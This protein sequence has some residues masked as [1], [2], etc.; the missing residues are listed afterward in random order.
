MSSNENLDLQLS[1]GSV[2]M[3]KD[4]SQVKFL[5]L[6]NQALSPKTQE[7]H[8]P[9]VI[10]TDT[11]GNVF[12]RELDAFLK[13]YQFYNVDGELEKRLTRLIV[14]NPEDYSTIQDDEDQEDPENTV[15][16]I[17]DDESEDSIIP[18]SIAPTETLAEQMYRELTASADEDTHLQVA[19]AI[20]QNP[21][22]RNPVLTAEDLAQAIVLYSNSPNEQFDITEHKLLF[23]LGGRITE[24]SLREVFHPSREVNTVDYFTVL[25]KYRKDEI[26]WDS[27]IGITPEYSVN[28]LYAAV[29]VGTANKVLDKEETPGIE[30]EVLTHEQAQAPDEFSADAILAQHAAQVPEGTTEAP[31]EVEVSEVPAESAIVAAAPQIIPQVVIQPQPIVAPIPKAPPVIQIMAQ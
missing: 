31:L 17:T 16:D 8:P 1:K 7:D 26:V 11:E 18:T 30:A 29:L 12:N 6:T 3:R 2:W 9:Q 5:F 20:S 24:E 27:W 10:Y 23:P 15:L 4:G 21:E 25:T 19:F 14:F 28:G 13:V 22:M